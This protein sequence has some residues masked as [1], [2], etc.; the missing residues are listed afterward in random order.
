ME[1]KMPR[2]ATRKHQR[3]SILRSI[4]NLARPHGRLEGFEAEVQSELRSHY[5]KT[6]V[7]ENVVYLPW[8]TEPV[9]QEMEGRADVTTTTGAGSIFVVPGKGFIDLLRPK[10]LMVR[11]G[12]T[13]L[14]ADLGKFALP[15]IAGSEAGQWVAEGASL[16]SGG[17]TSDSVAFVPRSLGAAALISRKFIYQ[18][19]LAAEM[20]VQTDLSKQL[21]NALDAA[22]IA[23]SGSGAVP[24][25]I[26][27]NAS[28][29]ALNTAAGLS[30]GTNGGALTRAS[31]CTLEDVLAEA[32]ADDGDYLGFI[33]SGR[34]RAKMRQTAQVATYPKWLWQS[35]VGEYG[36]GFGKV[37]DY[38]ALS[39]TNVPS[40]LTKASGSNL[41]AL[42]MGNFEHMVIAS[43]PPA[44]LLD[45]YTY[46]ASGGVRCTV[47]VEADVNVMHPESFAF[48]SDVNY[49]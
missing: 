20:Y 36:R 23:G 3:F 34:V 49:S 47:F 1:G 32:N 15:R 10:V 46:Q 11:L 38:P 21:A 8:G 45:P 26:L 14:E 18:S 37:L 7:A 4:A 48:Y 43:G 5:G 30:L 17:E 16:T 31:L 27:Y 44:V 2:V 40:N 28:I 35:G 29:Q 24:T 22:A 13:F 6:G 19:S 41:G 25:G 42:I 12:A 9:I 39:S 33:T